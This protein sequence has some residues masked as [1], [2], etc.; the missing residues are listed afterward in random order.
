MSGSKG[1]ITS[2]R[3]CA[4]I[5][6]LVCASPAFALELDC[7]M[8]TDG[9]KWQFGLSIDEA[10][11]TVTF[12]NAPDRY[13]KV[14]EGDFA[15]REVKAEMLFADIPMLIRWTIDRQNLALTR[16]IF[17]KDKAPDREELWTV[18]PMSVEVG[19][20]RLVEPATRK[21]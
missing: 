1:M 17:F 4:V 5:A 6:G 14:M 20:C 15:P 13:H 21:F 11:R 3:I 10:A 9:M 2:L 19:Q 12:V 7:N 16:K 18:E 8:V